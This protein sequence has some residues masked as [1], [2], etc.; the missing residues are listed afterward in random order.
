MG[1]LFPRHLFRVLTV[2]GAASAVFLIFTSAALAQNIINSGN[3]GDYYHNADELHTNLSNPAVDHPE[4][5]LLAPTRGAVTYTTSGKVVVGNAS[6]AYYHPWTGSADLVTILRYFFIN[7]Q[8]YANIAYNQYR[9]NNTYWYPEHRDHDV[10]DN[11]HAMTPAVTLSQG[12]SGSEM[13]EVKK[14]IWTLAA[15]RTETKELLKANGL[16]MP[17]LQMISRR[18]RVADDE[19]YLT[20]A[21][22]PSAFDNYNNALAMQQMAADMLPGQVPPMIQL[23][24]IDD[25][26]TGTAGT[27]ILQTSATQRL[28][29]TPVSISRIWKNLNYTNRILVS[30]RNS[31]DVNELPLTFHWKV[32]RGDPEHVRIIP[33]NARSSVVEIEID[34]HN[35]T[36]I[37][38]STR[39]TNMVA[40]GAFVHN[41]Y[42][43]SAP[44]FVSSY[45]SP[46]EMRT[47]EQQSG[48]LLEINYQTRPVL[49]LLPEIDGYPQSW[50]KD[51]FHYG[52]DSRLSGW[53]RYNGTSQYEFTP[54][55][56]Q[57]I[58]VDAQGK[59]ALVQEVN[60]TT[61]WTGS[62]SQSTWT[63]AGSP[64]NYQTG[65]QDTLP[66]S[67]PAGL[68]GSEASPASFKLT[69]AASTDNIAVAGYRIDAALDAGF[70]N[71]AAG[72][73][74]L[75]VGGST[76]KY[77][78]NLSAS[79]DYYVRVRAY[80]HSGNVSGA[81]QTLVVST[82]GGG[83]PPPPVPRGSGEIITGVWNGYN[84]HT[85]IIEC[86]N[87]LAEALTVMVTVTDYQ[88]QVLGE[89]II[90]Q[91][92]Y[93]TSH[94]VLN[95]FAIANS[96]GTYLLE[97]L[98][99]A[100]QP[101]SLRCRTMFYREASP[102]DERQVE[103]VFAVPA[104]QILRGKSSGIYNSMNPEPGAVRP[105]ANWL[106]LYNPGD[107]PLSVQVRVF[108]QDGSTSPERSFRIDNLAPGDR[109][110]TALGHPEG[111][112]TG[113]YQ[114]LPDDELQ[115][116]G[117]FLS[118]YAMARSGA[119]SFGFA[120]LAQPGIADSGP[121]A[122]ST[123][124]PAINWAEVANISENGVQVELEVFNR[125]G[126]ILM[127]R[128]EWIAGRA[129][130][131][132]YL[133]EPIGPLNVGFVRVRVV[134]GGDP[135]GSLVVQSMYYGC[136]GAA[137]EAVLWA[138]PSQA[139]AGATG[140]LVQVVPINTFLNSANWLKVFTRGEGRAPVE[141]RLFAMDGSQMTTRFGTINLA[142]SADIPLHEEV[143]PSFAGMAMISSAVSLVAE[144]VRV[145]PVRNAPIMGYPAGSITNVKP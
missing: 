93:G 85:N 140:A 141:I 119:Y 86:T 106:S 37:P 115:A 49:Q 103:Y 109:R 116:Y 136:R 8:Y 21:A 51:V 77:I 74:N 57:V 29:Q 129:Q 7:D 43:Y 90:E 62:M 133:N 118:R 27:D 88:R 18:T 92:A 23:E 69:W 17:A 6:L 44:G 131:H 124:G 38:D 58:S 137:L 95:D 108:N 55:G 54:E 34:Y 45:T 41:G 125:N 32:I 105:V 5:T 82:T 59:A 61:N 65:G 83:G 143:G 81:S 135:G 14:F 132:L 117:A 1:G 111:Q 46:V 13:D 123:M 15:F 68:N 31:F 101:G 134:E 4:L 71:F 127:S 50:S 36:V 114:I 97:V 67:V 142:G 79:T 89:R 104:G 33:Q 80:D 56:F 10:R 11:M 113:I 100:S 107:A 70:Q 63:L 24:V 126:Q 94:T 25:S 128:R 26:Y 2:F 66:P 16:L 73:N 112:V 121:L 120:L 22:H 98:S 12:S 138:Y 130:Y 28:Y 52:Q 91:P 75:D 139:P 39:T 78:L 110:D 60:Y 145:L 48:R 35:E 20:G 19:Q 40:V 87:S 9:N 99:T 72:Y 3:S 64:F 76:T 84:N 144:N 53:T 96:Y 30:A 47:Y 122:A 42:Y 102:P